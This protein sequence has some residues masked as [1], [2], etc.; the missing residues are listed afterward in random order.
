MRGYLHVKIDIA[1]EKFMKQKEI[2]HGKS[3]CIK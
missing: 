3:Y 2:K 1:N